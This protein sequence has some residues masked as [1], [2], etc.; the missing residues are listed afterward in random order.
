M[1]ATA[2]APAA[3]VAV[4][5][6]VAAAAATAVAATAAATAVGTADATTTVSRFYKWFLGRRIRAGTSCG[7]L[8]IEVALFQL[9]YHLNWE[10]GN[11]IKPN[12][13]DMSETFG[14]DNM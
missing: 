13:L 5:I 11:G 9:L 14:M 2:S 8:M 4:P 10:L 6:V 1:H 12:E 3:T 7:I